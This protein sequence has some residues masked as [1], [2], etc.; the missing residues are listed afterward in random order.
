MEGMIFLKVFFIGKLEFSL[1]NGL[2]HVAA[3]LDNNR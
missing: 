3:I 2:P 1:R